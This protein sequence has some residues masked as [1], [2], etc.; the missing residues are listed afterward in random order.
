MRRVVDLLPERLRAPGN[1]MLPPIGGKLIGR[2]HFCVA[3]DEVAGHA[4]RTIER[5][6]RQM[7][8]G[9]GPFDYAVHGT[10]A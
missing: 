10:D 9:L 8:R 6:G 4:V 3:S 5:N 1:L 7:V 2:W